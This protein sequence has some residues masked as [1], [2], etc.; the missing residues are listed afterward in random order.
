MEE[1]TLGTSDVSNCYYLS[2]TACLGS[3]GRYVWRGTLICVGIY[4]RG[5]ILFIFGFLIVFNILTILLGF[6]VLL[7]SSIF[8]RFFIW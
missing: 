8:L 7:V 4:F 1:V 6:A 3:L 5:I 2:L